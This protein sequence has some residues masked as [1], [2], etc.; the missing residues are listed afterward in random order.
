MGIYYINRFI[1][2][3]VSS[4]SVL[5]W[6]RRLVDPM[7]KSKVSW[8]AVRRFAN[9]VNRTRK[10]QILC[11]FNLNVIFKLLNYLLTQSLLLRLCLSE[12]ALYRFFF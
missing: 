2:Y 9:H 11:S 1:L 3:K 7:I 4:T 12:D 8:D 10:P 6:L 5:T